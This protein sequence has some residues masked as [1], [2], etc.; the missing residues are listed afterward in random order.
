M[1]ESQPARFTCSE[2]SLYKNDKSRSAIS[3]HLGLP[4]PLRVAPR[5]SPARV[6]KKRDP[7]NA[8]QLMGVRAQ[9]S[10]KSPALGGNAFHTKVQNI[11]MQSQQHN[12]CRVD[13]L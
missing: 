11:P 4:S 5:P 9:S 6:K 2:L 3:F 8:H 13:G 12:P 1:H 7:S 10:H